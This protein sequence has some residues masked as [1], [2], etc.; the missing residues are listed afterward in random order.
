[1][2]RDSLEAFNIGDLETCMTRLAPD[3]VISL[4][5]L[6]ETLHGREVLPLS[7]GAIRR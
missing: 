1:L 7:G 5:E 3:F 2:L 6:P 4:A